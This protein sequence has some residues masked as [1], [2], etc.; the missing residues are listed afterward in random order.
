[1][2]VGEEKKAIKGEAMDVG[3]LSDG[4]GRLMDASDD[5]QILLS[6]ARLPVLRSHNYMESPFPGIPYLRT[7]QPLSREDAPRS[8]LPPR[9]QLAPAVEKK[10]PSS[11]ASK[12]VR[13]N[14]K[15]AIEIKNDVTKYARKSEPT[16]AKRAGSPKD[17]PVI[18]PP[19]MSA[20]PVLPTMP[21]APVPPTMTTAPAPTTMPTAPAPLT[22][23]ALL[24]SLDLQFCDPQLPV[25]MIT[26][27]A[28]LSSLDL[29]IPPS[30][31]PN[32]NIQPPYS[33]P[34][35]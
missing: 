18:I 7:D 35:P 6:G 32:P 4:S 8:W 28:Y 25:P 10:P 19:T 23:S 11:T 12:P 31:Y 26:N 34:L 29:P 30:A 20:A 5:L 24:G 2:S 27:S 33:T 13:L 1:M 15:T 16:E 22:M 3:R 14:L 17:Q 9:M 21:T